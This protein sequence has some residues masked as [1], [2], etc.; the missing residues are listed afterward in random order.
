MSMEIV[1][2][3][4]AVTGRTLILPPD[5]PMYLL[6]HD[7]SNKRRGLSGFFDMTGSSFKK[8]V[9]VITTEEFLKKEATPNGQF[10]LPP[11]QY[12]ELSTLARKGCDKKAVSCGKIHDYLM[13]FGTTP[14]ITATHHQCLVVDHGMYQ[15]GKPDFPDRAEKFCSSGNR[16][17]VYLTKEFNRPQLLYIQAG[18][19]Q[20]RMLAHFYGYITFTDP[21]TDNYFK[22]YIRDLLH[23][24]HEIF[25]AAGNIVAALQAIAKD[26]GS[27]IDPEGYGGYSALHIRRGD[28]QYKN[29]KLSSQEWYENTKDILKKN[30]ILYISTD[31]R[32]KSFFEPFKQAGHRLFFLQDFTSFIEELD[33]NHMG[34]VETVVASQGRAFI[35]TFRSTF[36]GYINR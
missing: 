18:K 20:T 16:K 7:S 34:M 19:P 22:R 4:A 21:S 17:T 24:R 29:M 32:D 25:C 6:R 11:N 26:H 10:S 15:R 14:N 8:R 30:E 13:Q 5:Q 3:I 9:K 1:F 35:G 2:I 12:E 36:S 27:S 33:P 31:E 28:F 23:Y